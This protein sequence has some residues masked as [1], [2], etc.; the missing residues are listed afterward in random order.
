MRD[1]G[2]IPADSII[3]EEVRFGGVVGHPDLYVDG[4]LRDT[5]TVGFGVQLESYR[6]K[7]PPKQ[8]RWQVMT[9][10]AALIVA[11]HPVERVQLDYIARDSGN[12]WM[13]ESE[14]N[15]DDVA[16]AMQWLDNVRETE[17][18][19]LSRDYAPDSVFCKHCPF[20]EIC[21]EGHAAGRD[22]RSI[23]L[24]EDGDAVKWAAQLEVARA[25]KR[26]AEAMEAQAKGALDALRP[27][28][29]IGSRGEVKLD[30][31]PWMLRWTVS[32]SRRLDGDQVR[33]DYARGGGAAPVNVSPSVKLELIAPPIEEGEG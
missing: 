32:E 24:I 3:E 23:L 2:L 4:L 6:V 20:S 21:W 22:E 19:M 11:G 10:G 7:G 12:T 8:H 5:K 25:A 17:L 18:D 33:A 27:N 26:E 28:T 15:Y 29:K 14:F 16:D 30:G 31:F 9:Y 1:E 13:W